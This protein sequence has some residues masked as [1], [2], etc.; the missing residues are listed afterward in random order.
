MSGKYK[1]N[2]E[3]NRIIREECIFLVEERGVMKSFIADG[4]EISRIVMT[5]FI[6]DNKNFTNLVLDR[7]DGFLEETY[8]HGWL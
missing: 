2:V 3:R 1:V 5:H 4:S 7:L 8:R 6:R